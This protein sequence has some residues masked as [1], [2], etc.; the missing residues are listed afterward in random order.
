MMATFLK[1]LV[2]QVS[3]IGDTL[4]ATP[5]IR[6]IA[7]ACPDAK[8]TVMGHPNR[9]EVFRHLPFIAEVGS[10][11][12]RRS[13]LKGWFSGKPYD[14]AFVFGFDEELVTYALRVSQRVVS[15]R[16]D[17]E[18]LNHRLYRI[19][20]RP[21]F[22]CEHAVKQLLRL[23]LAMGW[24][25][26]GLR[27][28]FQVTD[29]EFV[30]AKQ[31]LKIATGFDS[32]FLVGLQVASFH[33]KSY[34]DWPVESFAELAKK[35][36]EYRP[37]ACFLLFG[38]KED[39]ERTSWLQKQL[40]GHAVEL[41]G[42]LSLRQ[43]AACM[44]LTQLY[45]GVDTGPTHIMSTFNI[46]MVALYHCLSLSY[47]SGPLEHPCCKVIDHI[48]ATGECTED[49]SMSDIGVDLVFDQVI[50]V[51]AENKSRTRFA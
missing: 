32:P 43:T 30:A 10:I 35:I 38:G 19:V 42:R 39:Q 50:N 15:F 8:I 13:W 26:D 12:K 28:A 7:A 49:S 37:N 47:Y 5:A 22:Q 17:N 41:A 3:R 40:G 18:K 11:E 31:I 14:L 36:L 16:Q 48:D 45:V 34:R 25:A 51:L 44:G 29:D 21:P 6:A 27:L 20:E 33:T 24:Q 1:I 4:F 46:P 23:P 2:I 9:A